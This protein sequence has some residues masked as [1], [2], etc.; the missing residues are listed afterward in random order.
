MELIVVLKAGHSIP[1]SINNS[2]N[3]TGFT[4]QKAQFC[5]MHG[6]FILDKGSLH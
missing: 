6:I 1:N 4:R 2:Y 5:Y 3:I